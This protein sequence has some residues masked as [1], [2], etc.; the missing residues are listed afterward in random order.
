MGIEDGVVIAQ[1]LVRDQSLVESQIRFMARRLPRVRA[2][3]DRS[4]ESMEQ[5]FDT[6]TEDALQRRYA[7]LRHDE[8][9]AN[10][11]SNR[12]LGQPY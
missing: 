9:I 7:W 6:L 10:E 12:L 2:V 4:M 11:Y 3:R 5:E 8:P 1:E